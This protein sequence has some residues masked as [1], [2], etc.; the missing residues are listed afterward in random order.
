MDFAVPEV[1]TAEIAAAFFQATVTLGLALVFLYLFQRYRKPYFGYWALAWLL[2]LLRMVVIIAFVFTGSRPLLFWH[3]VLTGLTALALL[4]AALVFS[5]QLTWKP[6][7]LVFV[8]FPAIWSYVAMYR[9]DNFLAAAAP[10]VV[11]LSLATLWTGWVFYR[12]DRRV[13]STG[14]RLLFI[15]LLLWSVHHLDY[16]FL[17]ARGVWSPWGYY[18]DI[19]FVLAMGAG[20]ML[21]VLEEL[22]RGLGTLSA[23][24]GD[25]QR[26]EG[27][28]EILDV[29]LNRLLSLP[30][31]KGA[32][33]YEVAAGKRQLIRGAGICAH[34]EKEKPRGDLARAIDTAVR[35]GHPEVVHGGTASDGASI[36]DVK[37]STYAAALPVLRES[38]ATGAI[39]VIGDSSDPFA[40]LDAR[41]LVALGQQIGV[42]LEKADLDQR[43][44]NRTAELERL[45]SRMVRQH[46]EQRRRISRELH[47]ETAQVFSAVKLNLGL[48]SESARAEEAARLKE[49]L[50]LI[51]TGIDSIRRVTQDL[52]P[53]VLDELGLLPALHA[54]VGD[55]GETTG[56]A[57]RFV[58]PNTLPE[59]SSEAELALFRVLQE[60]LTNVARHAQASAVEVTVES[61]QG[62]IVVHVR[63]DGLGL[64]PGRA[65]RL[66]DD[67]RLGLVGMRERIAGLGGTV[68]VTGEPGTGVDLSVHMPLDEVAT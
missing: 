43:L 54:L 3:Q 66:S 13:G 12:Y 40:A 46:E 44:R 57:I 50:E 62:Q 18:V 45:A 2:Y 1:T 29:L 34:W 41:F 24:S 53:S 8:A 9:L 32:A 11:F 58:A 21:L 55:F 15:S 19:I 38:E 25:L 22:H 31:V 64:G 37:E 16:P 65:D 56:L 68:S 47:D 6:R 63:D 39:V 36:V 61:K 60:G 49:V 14:A 59:L 7:Y 42:A 23:L 35:T 27:R 30:A 48:V 4:W 67:G 20:I 33:M 17:R 28:V 52:R 26:G 10:M 5:Q 51:D